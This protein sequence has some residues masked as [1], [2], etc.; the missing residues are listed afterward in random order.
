M[1]AETRLRLGLVASSVVLTVVAIEVAL[2]ASGYAP[3]FK[4]TALLVSRDGRLLLDCY[5]T[6]PRGYFALD[7]RSAGT[8]AAYRHLAPRRYEAVASR[9]PWAVEF[10]YNSSRF[11]GDEIGPRRSGVR[12]V[13]VLGDSF[14][15]GQGVKE[16]D[17]YPR[18]LGRLL[19]SAEPGR[20][21]VFNCGRRA[22]D[23]PALLEV[24]GDV[25]AL[26]P[27]LVVYGMV[28]NDADQS[29]EFRAR[30]TF[31]N[32]LILDHGHMLI[33]RPAFEP[34]LIDLR[35]L[36][37]VRDRLETYRIGRE[38]TRWYREMYGPPNQDGWRRTQAY[39]RDM[40]A[41]MRTRGGRLL[42][43]SWPLL[44]GLESR[45]PFED[46][47][48][49]IARSLAAGGVAHHDLLAAF[50]GRTSES[51]WVHPV[52]RHPNEIAHRLAAESLVAVVRRIGAEIQP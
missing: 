28:L 17:T 21:A 23:F 15:E 36:S 41:R 4:S 48:R 37:F 1:T 32:D 47:A 18:V 12:R 40:D 26:D 24:F 46:V 16:D 11:R 10:R 20:W 9:A 44:A 42:V 35:L 34:G 14:T 27:D 2:R 25:L 13:M 7:L 39:V 38:T 52:D 5:P 49:E 43:A 30:Q 31:V 6:N 29:P 8:R 33:G 19:E 3:A 51:L 50:R 22:T 45:Y